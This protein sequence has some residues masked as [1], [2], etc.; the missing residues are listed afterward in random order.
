M[1]RHAVLPPAIITGRG[2]RVHVSHSIALKKKTTGKRK[3]AD[4]V[5]I[6][7]AAMSKQAGRSAEDERR[8]DVIKKH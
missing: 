5:R 1:A 7:Q 2:E 4:L 8:L 3:T 6:R